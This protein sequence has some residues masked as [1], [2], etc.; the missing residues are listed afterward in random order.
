[1]RNLPA[2]RIQRQRLLTLN[3]RKWNLKPSAIT[4]VKGR[5]NLNRYALEDRPEMTANDG[6]RLVGLIQ[7][8]VEDMKGIPNF[9]RYLY[10]KLNTEQ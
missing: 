4:F 10:E 7:K 8:V 2:T 3:L 6:L 5:A 9:Y 1:M